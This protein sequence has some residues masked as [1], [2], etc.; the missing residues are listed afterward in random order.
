MAHLHEQL[1]QRRKVDVAAGVEELALL[2]QLG[3]LDAFDLSDA[4]GP[5]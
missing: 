5:R 3:N 1:L 2:G 4:E